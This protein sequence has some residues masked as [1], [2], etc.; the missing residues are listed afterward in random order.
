MPYRLLAST[1]AQDF[2]RLHSAPL[3]F[4]FSDTLP[5]TDWTPP[6]PSLM[7][8]PTSAAQSPALDLPPPSTAW[9]ETERMG[10]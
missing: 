4:G 1:S 7:Y 5:A 2:K 9:A 8:E 6:D 3:S 10:L